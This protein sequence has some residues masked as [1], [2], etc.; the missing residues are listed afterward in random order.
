MIEVYRAYF[1]APNIIT[2]TRVFLIPLFVFFIYEG[3][4]ADFPYIY[5]AVNAAFF[6]FI[7]IRIS[8][9]LDGWIARLTNKTS[10]LGSYL[11]VWSDFLFVFCSFIALNLMG[12]IPVWLTMLASYKFFEFLISSEI[13][14]RCLPGHKQKNNTVLHYDIPG[15]IASALFYSLPCIVLTCKL[16]CVDLNSLYTLYLGILIFTA[17]SSILKFYNVRKILFPSRAASDV[18]FL[19]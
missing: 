2:L 7:L 6:T 14:R 15:R 4:T 9:I 11:D 3:L 16:L 8:D 17:A 5:V 13:I 12:I 1:T 19:K 18:P 10:A